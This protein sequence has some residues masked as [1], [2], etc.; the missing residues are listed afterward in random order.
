MADFDDNLRE[1]RERMRAACE[2]S[3]RDPAAVD[4]VCVSKTMPVDVVE[5]AFRSGA[6]VFG[7]NYAQELR[8]KSRALDH[9]HGI[10]WHYIGPLQRNKVRYVVGTAALIHSV[11]SV[12][13]L[14]AIDD[15]AAKVDVVQDLLLQLNLSGE[16]TKSGASADQVDALLDEVGRC[17]HCRC[18]GLM[19]MPP[20]FDDPDRARPLFAE[21]AAI[22][23]RCSTEQRPGVDLRHLSMGMT[24][25]FEVAIAEGATLVRIGTALFGARR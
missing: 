22:A 4:L 16:A 5:N 20:F 24:G 6:R 17:A 10:A 13:I 8:D 14:R 12:E 7:E 18:L 23:R 11:H 25:D 21:L 2:R 1:V 3:G 19:T 9:L 15:R